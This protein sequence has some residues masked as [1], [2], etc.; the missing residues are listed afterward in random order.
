[1]IQRRTWTPALIEW[2]EKEKRE[3]AK[4][5]KNRDFLEIGCGDGS[6]LKAVLPFAKSVTGIDSSASMVLAAQEKLAGTGAKVLE[7]NAKSLEFEKECFDLVVCC[8]NTFGNFSEEEKVQDLREMYRVL[9]PNGLIWV[10]VYTENGA[11]CQMEHY[12]NVGLTEIKAGKEFVTTK[13][14]FKSE[15]FTKQKLERILEK[16]G[17]KGEIEE[18]TSI[19]YLV[20]IRK[21]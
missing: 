17:L 5:S 20:K 6:I 4:L 1:M 8:V 16:A 10:T 21:S 11:N 13:E 3:I 18:F 12:K 2:D 19:S 9:A 14:G 7:M 15:R